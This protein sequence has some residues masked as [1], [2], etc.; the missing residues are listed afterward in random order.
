MSRA[1]LAAV[2]ND[3]DT[4]AAVVVRE[5]A[6]DL[7]GDASEISAEIAERIH[8]ALAELGDDSETADLTR[9]CMHAVVLELMASARGERDPAAAALAPQAARWVHEFVRLGVDLDCLMRAARVGQEAIWE[10]SLKALRVRARDAALLGQAIEIASRQQFA[11]AEALS[12]Q[13][14]AEHSAA[15]SRW[16][17]SPAAVRLDVVRAILDEQCIDVDV[18]SARLG[19][20]LRREH[21]G[22]VVWEA[23]G[24]PEAGPALERSALALGFTLGGARPL[25]VPLSEHLLAGWVS[26]PPVGGADEPARLPI[27]SRSVRV[28]IGTRAAG[29]AGFK[30]SHLEA[31]NAR[32]VAILTG[33]A[34]GGVAHFADVALESL[35]STDLDQARA[36]VARELGPLAR[37]DE[38]SRTLATTLRAYLELG[39]SLDRAARRLGVHKNTVLKRVRRARELLGGDLDERTLEL[40]VALALAPV[41][42]SGAVDERERAGSTPPTAASGPPAPTGRP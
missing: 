17:R 28:A 39:S 26:G 7:R 12:S 9:D 40:E 15:H 18:A 31:M 27:P 14:A 29:V 38:S 22:F 42:A 13:L 30:H 1:A 24:A 6:A 34:P 37:G 41:V 25:L 2:A 5:A 10:R 21:V 33:L 8:T 11:Y 36:F 4:E 32:R 16:V 23:T 20:E 35:V 19:Y 3:V